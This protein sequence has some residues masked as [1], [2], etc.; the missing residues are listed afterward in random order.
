M[1][2]FPREICRDETQALAHEWRVTNEST[3]YASTSIAGAITRRHHGLLV[4]P[5]DGSGALTVTLAKV[6][7][8]IEV[9]GQQYKLGT[10]EYV[11]NV[12]EP[13]GY[14]YLQQVSFDG[15]IAEFFYEAGR[16]HLTKTIWLGQGHNTTF[17]RYTLAEHSAPIRLTLIPLCDYRVR[18]TL[19]QGSEQLRFH[20]QRLERGLQVT[21]FEGA[22]PYRLLVAP[23]FDFTPLDL[24]Y[25]R[26]QLRGENNAAADLYVP[27]LVRAQVAPG[28][29]FTLIATTES[30]DKIDFD[31]WRALERA[32]ARRTTPTTPQN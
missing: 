22:V 10:N 12:I 18:E 20:I 13:D 17:V 16:F 9:D 32:R 3:S 14:L 28:T 15:T 6:D 27:G 31:S 24:W 11:G 2:V 29:S 23:Q 8:E 4:A 30:D 25:W 26:F 21:A 5:L 19:T 1:T 7:E